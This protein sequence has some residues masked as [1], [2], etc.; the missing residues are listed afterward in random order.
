[1]SDPPSGILDIGT[2]DATIEAW[3]KGTA[4]NERAIISKRVFFSSQPLLG[5]R[6]HRRRQPQG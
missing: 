6:R 1:M 3:V 5:G 4:N 2:S